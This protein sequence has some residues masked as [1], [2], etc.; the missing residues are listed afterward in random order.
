[1]EIENTI[2]IILYQRFTLRN[3]ILVIRESKICSVNRRTL[4]TLHS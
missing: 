4:L 2:Y 3:G 1:M